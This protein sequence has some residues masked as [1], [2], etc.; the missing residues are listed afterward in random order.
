MLTVYSKHVLITE[1]HV[2]WSGGWSTSWSGTILVD[3]LVQIFVVLP[4]E[5]GHFPQCVCNP[6]ANHGAGIFAY[7]TGAFFW[8]ILL[9]DIPISMRIASGNR[10][11]WNGRSEA[12][13]DT[14]WSRALLNM[15]ITHPAVQDVQ[16]KPPTE[17]RRLSA[18]RSPCSRR[19][20][21]FA[22]IISKWIMSKKPWLP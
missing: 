11:G 18:T 5:H 17:W 8:P 19:L 1:H 20:L 3:L 7:N 16:G 2:V 6:D 4:C 9:V 14:V 13:I 21:G 22:M 10:N 12:W 15:P